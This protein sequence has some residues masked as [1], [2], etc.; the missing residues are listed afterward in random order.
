MQINSWC[1]TDKG[2]RRDSNQDS[3]LINKE[4]GLYIV[5]DGMGGHSGGEVA[6][7]LAVKTVEEFIKKN[8]NTSM[9][10]RE[11]VN[12]AYKA[13]SQKVFEQATKDTHLAGMGTT[14]VLCYYDGKS[15]FIG[16]VGD[17]RV[18]LYR[19]PY[20]WQ[21]TEDHSLMNEQLRAG[22]INED[23]IKTFASRN[24]IT[25]SVGYE[26]E[27]VVDILE[28]AAEKGDSFL[29]CS[30]GL[31]SLVPDITI[32]EV[33]NHTNPEKIV[34]ACVERALAHGGDDNVT[35]MFLQIT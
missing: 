5:A 31:S 25:R 18:Y 32:N 21:M 35:V 6:S 23:Q 4:L 33:L 9:P 17:S 1:L 10:S 28:R 3:F 16:N 15:V 12:Q 22:I 11:M 20:L 2:L 34:N 24:V 14:M 27:V 26:K 30:D 7:A 8:K 13:A 19:K 29:L